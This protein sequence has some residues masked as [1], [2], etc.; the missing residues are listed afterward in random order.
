[1]Y[2]IIRLMFTI[3]NKFL[4]CIA[5]KKIIFENNLL[6]D[7]ITIKNKFLFC[8]ANKKIIFENNLLSN[9]ITIKNNK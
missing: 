7:K 6:S 3:K 1:M 8:I 5:N 4:F 2:S 9:K